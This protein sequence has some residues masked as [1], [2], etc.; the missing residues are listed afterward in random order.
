M[1]GD[2]IPLSPAPGPLPPR[3]DLF[4]ELLA[5][6][7]R[8]FALVRPPTYRLPRLHAIGTA[9]RRRADGVAQ[10]IGQFVCIVM[11]YRGVRLVLAHQI[12][13][14][15]EG[16]RHILIVAAFVIVAAVHLIM[17]GGGLWALCLQ[18]N[19]DSHLFFFAHARYA[20]LS[21]AIDLTR[22][23]VVLTPVRRGGQHPTTLSALRQALA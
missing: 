20:Q 12:D 21:G 14:D 23:T 3:K 11:E 22:R 8:R 6:G 9:E 10:Q 4:A 17:D 13:C 15:R 1:K 16:P 5:R 2:G 7:C 19:G 18:R